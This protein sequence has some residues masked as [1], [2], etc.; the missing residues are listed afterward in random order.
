MFKYL[1][2]GGTFSF[3]LLHHTLGAGDSSFRP[4]VQWRTKSSGGSSDQV[5]LLLA[6]LAGFS[7]QNLGTEKTLRIT[8]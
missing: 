7:L 5:E 6:S 1:S 3:K 4:A 8:S 2:L